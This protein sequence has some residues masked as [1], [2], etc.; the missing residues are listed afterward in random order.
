LAPGKS[1]K[2]YV[3]NRRNH[4]NHINFHLARYKFRSIG[5]QAC[6]LQHKVATPSWTLDFILRVFRLL[7]AV[8]TRWLTCNLVAGAG[9]VHLKCCCHP[10][11]ASRGFRP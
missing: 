9:A 4:S 3:C 5:Q 6:H 8:I 2:H 11:R 1:R 7:R 10:G